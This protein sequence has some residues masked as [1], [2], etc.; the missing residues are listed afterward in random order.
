LTEIGQLAVSGEDILLLSPLRDGK[1]PSFEQMN[2]EYPAPKD[3][4]CQVWLKF[5]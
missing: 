5:A 2:L 1:S 4:L 3:D